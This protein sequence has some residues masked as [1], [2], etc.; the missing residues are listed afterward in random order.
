MIQADQYFT[1]KTNKYYLSGFLS[2][3]KC[4]VTDKL[5]ATPLYMTEET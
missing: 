5:K 2:A 1:E 4:V 3:T